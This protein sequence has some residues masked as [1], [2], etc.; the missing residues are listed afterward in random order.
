ME[1]IM[2]MSFSHVIIR[3]IKN[4]SEWERLFKQMIWN[5][6]SF[7]WIL[8]IDSIISFQNWRIVQAGSLNTN[9]PQIIKNISSLWNGNL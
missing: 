2:D 8:E 3:N 1:S 4:L 5:W 7:S 9:Y 6:F